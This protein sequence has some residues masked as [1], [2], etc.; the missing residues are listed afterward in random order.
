MH[1]Q[2][3]REPSGR[4]RLLRQTVVA[5][6]LPLLLAT[7]TSNIWNRSDLAAWVQDRAVEQG[8]RRDTITL[9]EWYRTE[10]GGNVWHGTCR[11]ASGNEQAFGINVDR[12]W[13]PSAPA[14]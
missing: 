4:A 14:S 10:A 9:D 8:C 2:A 11:D 13:T 1:R 3:H 6:S 12:V 7:C 5:T